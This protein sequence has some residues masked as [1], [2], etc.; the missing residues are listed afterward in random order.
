MN[1]QWLSSNGRWK[2]RFSSLTHRGGV[3]TGS[4]FYFS[5]AV[6]TSTVTQS[7]CCSALFL[8][9]HEN[10][11]ML[12]LQARYKKMPSQSWP[13]KVTKPPVLPRQH[14]CICSMYVEIDGPDRGSQS[15]CETVLSLRVSSGHLH[16]QPRSLSEPL[17]S[18]SLTYKITLVHCGGSHSRGK[19]FQFIHSVANDA[20]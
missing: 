11:E 2:N 9:M 19:L 3:S 17:P 20:D 7:C 10:W 12:Y 16:L 8:S 5:C 18:H 13:T 4:F 15:L 6:L 1:V 14:T